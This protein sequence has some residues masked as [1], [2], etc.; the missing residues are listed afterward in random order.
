M[1][2][3][4]VRHLNVVKNHEVA[5]HAALDIRSTNIGYANFA[6]RQIY[7]GYSLAKQPSDF[8]IMHQPRKISNEQTYNP[9]GKQ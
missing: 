3:E 9:L 5:L 7:N 8:R 4:E 6:P 1:D 2:A